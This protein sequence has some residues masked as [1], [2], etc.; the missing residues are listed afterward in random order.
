MNTN[1]PE[2]HFHIAYETIPCKQL[3]WHDTLQIVYL[4]T[5]KAKL[6]LHSE[7]YL[8]H[9]TDFVVINPFELHNVELLGASTLL[10]FYFPDRVTDC[11]NDAVFDCISC[12]CSSKSRTVLDQVRTE[13][14]ELFACYFQ[15][16]DSQEL[17]LL[18]HIYELLH[19][20]NTCFY[21]KSGQQRPINQPRI[22][23]I[24]QYL[25]LHYTEEIS[26]RDLAGQEYLS[27]NYLSQL[28]RE[29]L[30]T[31]FTEC[32]SSI[33][34]SHSFYELSNTSK[35]ITEIAL[36]NGFGRVD[37]FIE[38]FRRRYSITPGKYRKGLTQINYADPKLIPA[39]R[40][41]IAEIPPGSRFQ[42]LLHYA[43]QPKISQA[44]KQQPIIRH[45][46]VHGMT[47]S[48][49]VSHDWKTLVNAG[50][51]DDCFTAEAQQ[52]LSELK[53]AVGFDAV[54]FHG[55]FSDSMH[56]YDEEPNGKP[57]I[58]FTYVDLLLDRLLQMG[59]Q[60]YIEFSFLP[61]ALA[62][63]KT[64]VYQ[65]QSYISFPKRLP[66]WKCLVESFLKHCMIRYGR[67]TVREWKFSLFSISFSSYGFLSQEEYY[68][69]HRE[70]YR[71]VKAVD[72]ELIFCGPG[73]EGSQLLYSEDTICCDFLKRCQE[74]DCIPDIMTLHSFPHS[75]HEINSDF[76]R[77]VHQND[78]TATFQ[79]SSNE[80]FMS[81]AITGM[82]HTLKRLGLE[83]CPILID[84]WNSTI[85]QRDL[86]S[87]TCYKSVYVIKN[88]LETMGQT[89]GKAYWT[90]SDLIN[91]W[92][93]DE[94][95][96][97]GGHGMI[98]YNGI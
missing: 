16:N 85:W 51:A 68:Q 45:I 75:F 83:R 72:S 56:V 62:S 29:K 59:Y 44:V 8:M 22:T 31:T 79:L 96:F 5:G 47:C 64:S 38:R 90:V 58:H 19:L 92:K 70:T 3:H 54:R 49:P 80:H 93:I 6:S 53:N 67:K 7:Q 2:H 41:T 18:S 26:L 43:A 24:L 14:A 61:R 15:E 20:L 50:Y 23:Q 46:A 88:M 32:L 78:P 52:Q 60:L 37:N 74:E 36:D 57:V 71:T 10:E 34:L 81:D 4:L 55:I 91:D 63:Q 13:L 82:K 27:P 87:D 73:I 9:E 94:K 66:N 11:L 48:K 69:L 21:S 86:C 97:H 84:E 28:F 25:N 40:K 17:E 1:I 98:T 76:N 42:S 65:N 89:V 33:R 12:L 35:S 39:S 30:N 95:L 77:M